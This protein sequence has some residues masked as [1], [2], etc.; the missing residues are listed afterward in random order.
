MSILIKGIEIPKRC[1][2]CPCFDL[3]YAECQVYVT[4]TRENGCPLVDVPKPH[5]R[6]IDEDVVTKEIIHQLGVKD[7]TKL[8]PSENVIYRIISD[9]P[10]VIEEEQEHE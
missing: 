6:L 7:K 1:L 5:G 8:L 10:T 9:A 3:D 4:A 2:D